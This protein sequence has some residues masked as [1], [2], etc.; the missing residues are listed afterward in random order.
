MEKAAWKEFLDNIEEINYQDNNSIKIKDNLFDYKYN[1]NSKVTLNNSF[2]ADFETWYN[3]KDLTEN[4]VTTIVAFAMLSYLSKNSKDAKKPV[5]SYVEDF[6]PYVYDILSDSNQDEKDIE[7]KEN[8]MF[9]KMFDTMIHLVKQT[10]NSNNKSITI[11]MFNSASYDT[12]YLLKYLVKSGYKQCWDSCFSKIVKNPDEIRPLQEQLQMLIDAGAS[13]KAI[14]EQRKKIKKACKYTN[15]YKK[16][17]MLL[18]N[19]RIKHVSFKFVY[20]G[21]IFKVKDF[22]KFYKTSLKELGNT[23]GESKVVDIGDKYY[24]RDYRTLNK[25][26]WDEYKYYAEID[27]KILWKAIKKYSG[28]LLLDIDKIDTLSSLAKYRWEQ[29]AP[30]FKQYFKIKIDDDDWDIGDCSYRGGFSFCNEMHL[31]KIIHNVNAYDI[32]S[33]YPSSMKKDVAVKEIKENELADNKYPVAELYHI[34]FENFELKNNMLPIIPYISTLSNNA[35]YKDYNDKKAEYVFYN[36]KKNKKNGAVF[37]PLRFWIWKEELEWFEKFYDNVKYKMLDKKY[38]TCR[39]IF[40][41][42]IDYYYITKAQ[43]DMDKVFCNL[44]KEYID[45]RDINKIEKEMNHIFPKYFNDENTLLNKDINYDEL[46]RKL[47]HSEIIKINNFTN[48]ELE[49]YTIDLNNQLQYLESLRTSCKLYLNNLYGKFGQDYEM[50]SY[51]IVNDDYEKDEEFA[52]AVNDIT[53]EKQQLKVKSKKMHTIFDYKVYSTDRIDVIKEKA[54]NVFIASYITMLSRCKLYEV[55][56]RYGANKILYGDT[57]SVKI[58]GEIDKSYINNTELGKWKYEGTYETFAF[59]GSKKYMY[60]DTNNKF[61]I[62]IA[63]ANVIDENIYPNWNKDRKIQDRLLNDFINMNLIMYKKE[64]TVHK[65][66]GTKLIG[67]MK[68][69]TFNKKDIDNTFISINNQY[70]RISK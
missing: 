8:Q 14:A 24:K 34:E 46:A 40:D 15:E 5:A 33:S 70:D 32:N 25:Q 27:V 29:L 63:G 36:N 21:Y 20:K 28:F 50:Q 56:Y 61:N 6:N 57:D 42:Y 67:G 49:N 9:E 48:S 23:I 69:I 31:N 44:L 45:E 55:I 18:G 4:P 11:Y 41:K 39:R 43:A 1:N 19:D 47:I 53:L 2:V 65:T 26:E 3:A 30:E 68:A 58:I 54:N 60:R 51:T 17:F 37:N 62:H 64:T 16:E 66:T 59:V 12:A 22:C 13:D 35:Y 52:I 7:I 10:S 38:F